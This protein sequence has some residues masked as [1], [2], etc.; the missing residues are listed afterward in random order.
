[1]LVKVMEYKFAIME[2]S[3]AIMEYNFAIMEYNFAIMEYNFAIMEYT[4]QYH[5][6]SKYI[7][8]K[9]RITHFCS[10]LPVLGIIAF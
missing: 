6:G 2:Y 3:F 4:S 9:S 5:F 7:I 1:M 8:D 10:S